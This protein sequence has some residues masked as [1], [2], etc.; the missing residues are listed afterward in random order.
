MGCCATCICRNNIW[1]SGMRPQ[2]FKRSI[3]YCTWLY[4]TQKFP[5]VHLYIRCFNLEIDK[6]YVVIYILLHVFVNNKVLLKRTSRNRKF[7]WDKDRSR[8]TKQLL[9]SNTAKLMVCV[10]HINFP[11]LIGS[12][13]QFFFQLLTLELYFLYVSTKILLITYVTVSVE[14]QISIMILIFSQKNSV[15]STFIGMAVNS[16]YNSEND[17]MSRLAHENVMLIVTSIVNYQMKLRKKQK[18]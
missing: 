2:F 6:K 7:E 5:C 16:R 4:Y 17:V 9:N 14:N 18:H 13:I 11:H 8:N 10:L 15:N 1:V 12:V 3:V